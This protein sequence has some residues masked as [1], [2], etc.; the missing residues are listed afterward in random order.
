M[1]HLKLFAALCCAAALLAACDTNN[2]PTSDDTTN[3]H[4]CVDLGLSVK[5]ATMNVGANTPEAYG[6]YFAWGEVEPKKIGGWETYKYCSGS[7]NTWTDYYGITLS[8]MTKY[9]TKADYGLDGFIDNKILLEPEDDAAVKNWG[10][11]WRM[12]TIEEWQELT[13]SCEWT[14]TTLNGVNGY[15]VKS[16]TNGNS[17]FLPAAGMSNF[18]VGNS[19]YYWTSSL[20]TDEPANAHGGSFDSSNTQGFVGTRSLVIPIRP[21]LK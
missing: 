8:Y 4:E 15:E 14:W 20:F 17:I 16:K 13:D 9:C 3:G 12:A 19:G 10:G 2:E 6:D 21:V 18:N 1:K 11:A 7:G 5:W